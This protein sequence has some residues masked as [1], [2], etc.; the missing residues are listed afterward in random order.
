VPRDPLR[1][2][3]ADRRAARL[4]LPRLPEILRQLTPETTSLRIGTLDDAPAMKI[5]ADIWTNSAR[6]WAHI[7]PASARFP[8]QP[9]P[10]AVT[11]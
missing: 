4:P 1:S 6:P 3:R 2:E 11:K 10:P 9:D 5:T 8:G 7:D